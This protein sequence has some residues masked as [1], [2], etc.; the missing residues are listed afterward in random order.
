MRGMTGLRPKRVAAAV[1]LAWLSGCVGDPAGAGRG[2]GG[3]TRLAPPRVADEAAREHARL[4]QSFDGEYRAPRLQALLG[5]V[6][7]RLVPATERPDERY[8]VT[9]LNSPVVNAFALPSGA[10]TSPAG[11]WRS[12]TAPPRWPR[13]W[14]TRSPM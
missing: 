11:F 10:S 8:R 4:V 2:A 6:T 5:E 1:V 3:Q 14:P 7:G 13:F 9:I 12:P